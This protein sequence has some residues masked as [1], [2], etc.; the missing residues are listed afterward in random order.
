M[1]LIFLSEDYLLVPLDNFSINWLYWPVQTGTVVL[2]W[3][4]LPTTMIVSIAPERICNNN[5]DSWQKLITET[6]PVL[7]KAFEFPYAV[8]RICINSKVFGLGLSCSILWRKQDLNMF[9][10]SILYNILGGVTRGS[11]RDRLLSKFVENECE[12]IDR[13]MEFYIR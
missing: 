9:I 3:Y 10:I 7:I 11:R 8:L 13:L 6:N 1:I 4:Q 2:Q 12:K 5:D